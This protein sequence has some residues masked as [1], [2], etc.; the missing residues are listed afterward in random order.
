[1]QSIE[2]VVRN[3]DEEADRQAAEVAKLERDLA[4]YRAQAEKPF[5]QEERF[6]ELLK[7][8]AELNTQLDLDKGDRQVAEEATSEPGD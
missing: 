5:E 4:D 2:Y 1:M 3:L 6:R 7:R 8:Q